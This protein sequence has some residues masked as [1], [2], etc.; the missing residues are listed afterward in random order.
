MAYLLYKHIKNK[1]ANRATAPTEPEHSVPDLPGGNKTN[2]EKLQALIDQNQTHGEDSTNSKAPMVDA[3]EAE[4]IKAETS[5][6][7]K[8]RWK[9]VAGLILPN[10]LASVDTTI[11]APAVPIISSHFSEFYMI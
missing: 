5:R 4:R 6:R 9:M 3:E 11:V 8:Y 10:F 1:R 2:P 7:R